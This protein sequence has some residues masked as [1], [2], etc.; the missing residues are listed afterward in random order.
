M[1]RLVF[2]FEKANEETKNVVCK[3]SF[4]SLYKIDNKVMS[5][6]RLKQKKILKS[7]S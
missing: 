6:A 4:T 2:A 5:E 1:I 3:C 7:I